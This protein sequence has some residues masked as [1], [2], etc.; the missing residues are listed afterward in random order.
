MCIRDR[1]NAAKLAKLYRPRS[2]RYYF[3]LDDVAESQCHCPECQRYSAADAALLVYNAILRGL[4]MENPDA[5]QCFLAYHDTN[6]SLI[7]IEMCIRDRRGSGHC[8]NGGMDMLTDA[9]IR[10]F[11]KNRADV[12]N[13][14]VRYAYGRLAGASGL[15][16]NM[17]FFA[18]KLAAGLLSGSLAT[19][20]YTHL[21]RRGRGGQ[22]DGCHTGIVRRIGYP[23]EAGR[24]PAA[25]PDAP[26]QFPV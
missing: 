7:H 1:E 25:R 16:A 18:A 8:P 9:L 13:D 23:G 21:F 14:R 12:E 15:A 2:N 22:R 4:R 3:W 11:V 17:L 26:P 10:R 19:V 20:S 24:F 6:L 5:M